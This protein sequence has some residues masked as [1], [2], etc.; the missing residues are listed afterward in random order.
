[1]IVVDSL[2]AS[3]GEALLIQRAFAMKEEGKSRRKSASGWNR[4]KIKWS[5]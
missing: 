4:I 5:I 1:M 3:V 2:C